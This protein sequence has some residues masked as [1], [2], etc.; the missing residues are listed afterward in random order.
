MQENELRVVENKVTRKMFGNKK[1]ELTEEDAETNRMRWTGHVA[2][3][4][5]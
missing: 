4:E 2:W 1:E 3:M 5:L